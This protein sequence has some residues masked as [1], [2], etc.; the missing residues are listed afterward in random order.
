MSWIKVQGGT[1]A[2][3]GRD[4]FREAESAKEIPIEY[5]PGPPLP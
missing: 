2:L 5:G 1:A 3:S 4:I